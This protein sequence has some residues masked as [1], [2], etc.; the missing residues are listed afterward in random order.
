[1]PL[2]AIVQ[3]YIRATK[4]RSTYVYYV[5]TTIYAY[6]RGQSPDTAGVSCVGRSYTVLQLYENKRERMVDPKRDGRVHLVSWPQHFC[7]WIPVIL[8]ACITHCI[9][10]MYI[11]ISLM[12]PQFD[13]SRSHKF[14]FS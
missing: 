13:L 14:P 8:N 3:L 5:N 7:I 11:H 10:V 9:T 12:S 1:M 6:E 4:F 2:V